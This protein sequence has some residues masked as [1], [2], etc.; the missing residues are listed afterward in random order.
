[1]EKELA[2]K[3]FRQAMH[4]EI[5]KASGMKF[6]IDLKDKPK[7]TPRVIHALGKKINVTCQSQ[8]LDKIQFVFFREYK[9][10]IF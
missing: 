7:A 8:I 6:S 5:S 2:R 4:D 3:K 1:M 9:M 10:G